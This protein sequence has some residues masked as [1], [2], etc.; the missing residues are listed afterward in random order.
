MGDIQSQETSNPCSISQWAAL[1]AITGP[2]ESVAL[3]KTEFAKR[4]LYVLERV[5]TLPDVTCV[6]P[7]GAFYAFMN[8]SAHFGRTLGGKPIPDSTAFCL[9]A[10]DAAHVALVMGS[11]F[12]AEGFARLSFATDMRTLERGFDALD[13]FLRT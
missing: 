11:A 13:K 4:R 6:A 9:V 2:Q 5:K 10:L 3:M 7:G 12:G 8:V 1:E